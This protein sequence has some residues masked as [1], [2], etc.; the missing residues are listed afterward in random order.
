MQD[1]VHDNVAQRHVHGPL[2]L[3]S[4]SRDAWCFSPSH[5]RVFE[6]FL[7]L[8]PVAARES[9]GTRGRRVPGWHVGV[10]RDL[11]AENRGTSQRYGMSI[12]RSI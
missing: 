4:V 9:S 8:V 3:I 7:T 12:S 6:I 1:P 11:A 5:V 10:W 2:N